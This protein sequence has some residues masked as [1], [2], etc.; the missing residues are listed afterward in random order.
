MVVQ[1]G[2]N[3]EWTFVTLGRVL[4]GCSSGVG[5]LH[6][7]WRIALANPWVRFDAF[8]VVI[9]YAEIFLTHAYRRSPLLDK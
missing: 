8:L 4:K 2:N 7:A 6:S 5:F 9:G 3:I 1:E